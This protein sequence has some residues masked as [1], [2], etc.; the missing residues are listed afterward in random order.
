MN[1]TPQRFKARLVC[2]KC[3]S[4][5]AYFMQ[6]PTSTHHFP[7]SCWV[8]DLALRLRKSEQD[9]GKHLSCWLSNMQEPQKVNEKREPKREKKHLKELRGWVDGVGWMQVKQLWVYTGESFF[10]FYLVHYI[11]M[12]KVRNKLYMVPTQTQLRR[13][14]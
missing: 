4:V 2:N 10:F 5:M 7:S 13:F 8:Q 12:S 3:Q 9:L 14:S 6:T 1:F 11:N